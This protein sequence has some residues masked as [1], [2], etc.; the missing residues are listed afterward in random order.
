MVP[1]VR[2][3]VGL[4]VGIGWS[5]PV[6]WGGCFLADGVGIVGWVVGGLFLVFGV[7]ASGWVE[8][9]GKRG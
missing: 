7:G 4:L 3:L 9:G 2:F 6:G 1:L 5:C 8:E